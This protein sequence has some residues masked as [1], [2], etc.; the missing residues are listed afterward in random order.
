LTITIQQFIIIKR[1]DDMAQGQI[2]N[3]KI[4]TTIVMEKDLKSSLES[5]AKYD[6]RSLNNLMV[7]VLTEY[8]K[9]RNSD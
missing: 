2:S 9:S 3:K 4:K 5:I 8:V 1:G 6:M 7:S